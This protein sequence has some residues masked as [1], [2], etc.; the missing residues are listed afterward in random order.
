MT[1]AVTKDLG[2]RLPAQTDAVLGEESRRKRV[3]GE[4][5]RFTGHVIV[6]VIVIVIE[7]FVVVG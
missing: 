4:Y 5:L 2:A 7:G 1:R 3:V 6:I